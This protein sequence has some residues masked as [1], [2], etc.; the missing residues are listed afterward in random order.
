MSSGEPV[1]D[2]VKRVL[3]EALRLE[4]GDGI[5]DDL[6]LTGGDYDLD[7]LDMLLILTSLEKEFEIKIPY[8]TLGPHVF[9][10]VRTVAEYISGAIEREC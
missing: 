3:R 4:D 9:A 6:E 7:S 8:E 10:S 5:T 1:I 2:G